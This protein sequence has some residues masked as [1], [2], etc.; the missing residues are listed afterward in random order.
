[1]WSWYQSIIAPISLFGDHVVSWFTG[2]S[3]KTWLWANKSM[4]MD[5]VTVYPAFSL[6]SICSTL[7]FTIKIMGFCKSAIWQCAN[8]TTSKKRGKDYHVMASLFNCLSFESLSDKCFNFNAHVVLLN[9]PLS[10]DMVACVITLK[11]IKCQ[12]YGHLC[13]QNPP[14]STVGIPQSTKGVYSLQFAVICFFL[15]FTFKE[16]SLHITSFL[17][18]KLII[19]LWWSFV[20]SSVLLLCLFNVQVFNPLSFP[21]R[22][23]PSEFETHKGIQ[24]TIEHNPSTVLVKLCGNSYALT[25]HALA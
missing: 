5:D 14:F 23:I 20:L 12:D 13:F 7:L 17:P 25:S 16:G 4:S 11:L 2:Q 3:S 15:C 18:L 1:M 10:H 6:S 19:T 9:A 22:T 8:H 21:S 24:R